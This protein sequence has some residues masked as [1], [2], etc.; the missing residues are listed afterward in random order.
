MASTRSFIRAFS[1]LAEEQQLG[2]RGQPGSP[3]YQMQ[4]AWLL[5]CPVSHQLHILQ[6]QHAGGMH[7]AW[8]WQAAGLDQIMH[9]LAVDLLH[10]SIE[11]CAGLDVVH[12]PLELEVV[13][14]VAAAQQAQRAHQLHRRLMRHRRHSVQ[15]AA[16]YMCEPRHACS[17]GA[18]RWPECARVRPVLLLLLERDGAPGEGGKGLQGYAH[19]RCATRTAPFAYS[20]APSTQAKPS[21]AV[22]WSTTS[23]LKLLP[24]GG[25]LQ[26]YGVAS[27]SP[28]AF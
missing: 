6:Q 21:S 18:V 19:A 16:R 17:I 23:L 14:Q 28:L 4:A 11:V 10:P 7:S 24:T 12:R 8:W 26:W 15:G 25:K 1:V 2:V 9:S 22:A 3:A 27:H 13:P 5:A 20:A